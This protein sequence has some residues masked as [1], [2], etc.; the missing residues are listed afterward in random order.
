[1]LT[2]NNYKSVHYSLSP[3]PL[4]PI[5]QDDPSG[6]LREVYNTMVVLAFTTYMKWLYYL[7]AIPCPTRVDFI[8]ARLGCNSS[9]YNA[10]TFVKSK[11]DVRCI[12]LWH[13]LKTYARK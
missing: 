5:F 4:P 1:M 6:Q 3:P 10:R 11:S 7:G 12:N 9:K 13:L 8:L 2:R